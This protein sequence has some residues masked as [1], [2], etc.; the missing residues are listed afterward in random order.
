MEVLLKLYDFSYYA[1]Q[2]A[3]QRA[4]QA[5]VEVVSDIDRPGAVIELKRRVSDWLNLNRE[6]S[7]R[8]A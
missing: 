8:R 2:R 4:A 7:R 6:V 3:A 1:K 5:V